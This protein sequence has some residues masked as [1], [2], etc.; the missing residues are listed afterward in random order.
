MATIGEKENGRK[1]SGVGGVTPTATIEYIILDADT[2]DVALN[3]LQS[4]APTTFDLFGTGL[5]LIPRSTYD[6]EEAGNGIWTGIAQYNYT[7]VQTSDMEYTFETAGGSQHIVRSLATREYARSGETAPPSHGLIGN[8]GQ[9]IEGVD[10]SV[11][12]FQWSETYPVNPSFFTQEYKLT[13]YDLTSRVN[14][15]TFRGFPA[16]SV[17]FLGANAVVR[18]Y[19]KVSYL[20]LRFAAQEN[21][22]GITLD[23]IAIDHKDGWEYMTVRTKMIAEEN[24]LNQKIAGVYIHRTF[25][26]GDFSQLLVGP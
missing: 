24:A 18:G 12:T 7:D 3:L 9:S 16:G 14:Q 5:V 23:G 2:H 11:P 15:N 22:S 13:C 17:L 25:E 21:V 6:V 20:T 8:T 1:T 4:T 26:L 10:I 19:D